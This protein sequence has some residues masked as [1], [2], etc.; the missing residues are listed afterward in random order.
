MKSN[1]LVFLL[2]LVGTLSFT[3]ANSSAPGKNVGV[4][5]F[6]IDHDY[7]YPLDPCGNTL[8]VNVQCSPNSACSIDGNM[9]QAADDYKAAHTN[10][11]GCYF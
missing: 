2:I 5:K 1:L 9:Q 3:N 10:A 4:K 11:N 8:T 6:Q 7:Q